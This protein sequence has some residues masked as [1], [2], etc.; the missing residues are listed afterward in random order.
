VP[1]VPREDLRSTFTLSADV[2][3]DL[4]KDRGGGDKKHYTISIYQGNLNGGPKQIKLSIGLGLYKNGT[5][6]YEHWNHP[7]PIQV[8]ARG[9]KE[10]T[11]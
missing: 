8:L 1:I 3:L 6:R 7:T 11:K 4:Y 2:V 10:S 9:E 5:R